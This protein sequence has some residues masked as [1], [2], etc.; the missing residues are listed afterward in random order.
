MAAP[1]GSKN[2]LGNKGGKPYSK[3]NRDKSATLKGLSLDWMIEVMN[4][5]DEELKEK[6][7]LRIALNCIPQEHRHSGN[8]DDNTPI[9][10]VNIK[11][12]VQPNNSDNK[13]T[14]DESEDKDNTGGNIG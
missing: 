3:E 10:I 13:D 5:E 7:V 8:E 4:G 9:P 6:V 11:D 1:I 2:A 14:E 12:Y